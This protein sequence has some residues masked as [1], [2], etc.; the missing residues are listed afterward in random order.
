MSRRALVE[1]IELFRAL[2]ESVDEGIQHKIGPAIRRAYSR[3]KHGILGI[4][5]KPF[6]STGRMGPSE[7]EW[8][9]T[10]PHGDT[11][12]RPEPEPETPHETDA[13]K[14]PAHH[15]H[16]H[17]HAELYN[18]VKAAH[19]GTF[20]AEH[21]QKTSAV[22]GGDDSVH[23]AIL[24]DRGF[25]K[26]K[27][28]GNT[29]K[30]ADGTTATVSKQGVNY[31]AAPG[32]SKPA[33]STM[34]VKPKA[35]P[36]EPVKPKP[37]TSQPTSRPRPQ[38]TVRARRPAAR[39]AYSGE[40]KVHGA[41]ERLKKM[42]L[43]EAIENF[44]ALDEAKVGDYVTTKAGDK[45]YVQSVEGGK[46]AVRRVGGKPSSE[47]GVFYVGSGDVTVNPGGPVL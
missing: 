21:S 16:A 34:T 14:M 4:K 3:F 11:S 43:R 13:P 17:A 12:H 15:A 29:W 45:G 30:H 39:S 44:R 36:P 20:K 38:L 7:T 47:G 1:S 9:K 26:T 19:Q 10:H 5:R 37:T 22:K 46:L 27:T 28:K 25:A 2:D 24:R 41:V 35:P 33:K 8:R 31:K 18:S 23:H 40:P 32:S 42:K 6:E